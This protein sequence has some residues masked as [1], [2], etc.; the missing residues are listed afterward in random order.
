MKYVVTEE[1]EKY[2]NKDNIPNKTQTDLNEPAS[3][4]YIKNGPGLEFQIVSH[5]EEKPS[6]T[7]P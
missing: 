4:G 1:K 7:P 3:H 5:K 2:S 6:M